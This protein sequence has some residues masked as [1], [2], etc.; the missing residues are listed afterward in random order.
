VG[1]LF[2]ADIGVPPRLL[3]DLGVDSAGLFAEDDIIE[4]T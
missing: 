1:R 2:L 4:L 3:S